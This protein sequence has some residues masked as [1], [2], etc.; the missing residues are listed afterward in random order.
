MAA[1]R[2]A[3]LPGTMATCS[4]EARAVRVRRGSMLTMRAPDSVRAR[5]T[6]CQW[7]W[8]VVSR[9][10]PHSSTRSLWAISSGSKPIGWPS[11]ARALPDWPQMLP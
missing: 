4:S 7:W 6:K 9:F 1:A 5:F 10:E 8:L 3:S 11:A 2:A